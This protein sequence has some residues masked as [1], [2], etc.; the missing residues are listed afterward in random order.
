MLVVSMM[1]MHSLRL[2]VRFW[3]TLF[4]SFNM[5]Q[6]RGMELVIINPRHATIFIR[7]TF[8]RPQDDSDGQVCRIVLYQLCIEIANL[9]VWEYFRYIKSLIYTDW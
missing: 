2:S 4:L 5:R 1:E 3:L 7:S 6:A 9:P 8:E